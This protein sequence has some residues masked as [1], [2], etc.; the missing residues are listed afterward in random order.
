MDWS[1]AWR[2][3]KKE[4]VLAGRRNFGNMMQPLM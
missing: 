3:A 1:E 4:I 2:I